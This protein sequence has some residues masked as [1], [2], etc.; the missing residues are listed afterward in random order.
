M[1]KQF[2]VAEADAV[3]C[4]WVAFGKT[5]AEAKRTLVRAANDLIDAMNTRGYLGI[6]RSVAAFEDYFGI[7]AHTV[8]VGVAYRD[9]SKHTI[10]KGA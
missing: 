3:G 5:E 6:T 1:E 10:Q 9:G 7:D 4:S 8:E 2:W